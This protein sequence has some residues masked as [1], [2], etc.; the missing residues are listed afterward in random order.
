VNSGSLVS[1]V[2]AEPPASGCAMRGAG[3][4]STACDSGVLDDELV[5]AG[6]C[7]TSAEAPTSPPTSNATAAAIGNR[8]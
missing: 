2:K 3:V 7:A 8:L 4:V 5:L 6:V 1:S